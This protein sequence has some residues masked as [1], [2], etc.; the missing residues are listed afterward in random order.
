MKLYLIEQTKVSGYDTYDSAVVV[1]NSNEEARNIHP[2]GDDGKWS[3]SSI[4]PPWCKP[5]DVIVTCIG[6]AAEGAER[7]VICASYNA[8]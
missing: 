1:A 8:G 7:G 6:V 2:S 4:F 3:E 5:E